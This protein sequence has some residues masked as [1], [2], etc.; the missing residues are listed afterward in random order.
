[1][2]GC[3]RV[4]V[5]MCVCVCVCVCACVCVC[6]GVC[7]H[8]CMD[9]LMDGIT[10]DT[11]LV[12]FVGLSLPAYSPSCSFRGTSAKNVRFV[13]KKET[14]KWTELEKF[15]CS[16]PTPFIADL[17]FQVIQAVRWPKSRGQTSAPLR[18]CLPTPSALPGFLPRACRHTQ[19]MQ[20]S[21]YA[22]R[23]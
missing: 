9:G 5:C 7:M 3:L 15:S 13:E 23:L 10:R 4:C 11:P 14:S 21:S 1:M 2:D 8:A 16:S 19:S 18:S 12:Q 20:L 22:A 6:M 17:I